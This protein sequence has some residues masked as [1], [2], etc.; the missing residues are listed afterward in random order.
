MQICLTQ[1]GA[2]LQGRE[3]GLGD[4]LFRFVLLHV[5]DGDKYYL[6]CKYLKREEIELL[7]DTKAHDTQLT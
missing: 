5:C 2:V 3:S 7:D 6:D 4:R 1:Q